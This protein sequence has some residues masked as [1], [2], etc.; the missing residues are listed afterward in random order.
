P[1]ALALLP[2]KKRP[3]ITHQAGRQLDATQAAYDKAEVKGEVVEFID[4]M[5]QAWSQADLAICR[6]GAL[7]V[8]ELAAA[9]VASILVP[10]P[11]AVDDHQ[12]ANARYLSDQGAAWLMPQADLTPE[13]LA[14][15]LASLN[16]IQLADMAERARGLARLQ[17][18]KVVAAACQEVLA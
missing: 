13:T 4:D 9:G 15:K 17:A 8:A 7:T 6:A 2:K 3:K 11:A 10:F 12:T 1:Q 14:E 16:R 18:A 5:A